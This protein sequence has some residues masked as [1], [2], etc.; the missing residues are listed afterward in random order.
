MSPAGE[1]RH[2]QVLA[3]VQLGLV[4]DPPATGPGA[5]ALE[6]AAGVHAEHA[7]RD[8]VGGGG[9][10]AR[11]QRAVDELGHQ[12]RRAARMSAELARR[13]AGELTGSKSA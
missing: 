8:G 2:E 7:G 12:V 6:R 3:E 10:R 5:A 13:C 11:D 4:E 1:V 9:A